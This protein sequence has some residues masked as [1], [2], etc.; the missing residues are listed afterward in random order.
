VE[1]LARDQGPGPLQQ[2]FLDEQ[3]A[4]CAY[5]VSGILISATQLL[6]GNCRPTADEVRSALDGHLCRC[7]AHQRMVRAVLRA[8]E[9]MQRERA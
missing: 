8:A 6:Q 2:A 7:G 5:C 3:A 1:G 4:Q 9:A